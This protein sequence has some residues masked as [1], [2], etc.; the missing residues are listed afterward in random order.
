MGPAGKPLARTYLYQIE[1]PK[2]TFLLIYGKHKVT[3]LLLLDKVNSISDIIL[4]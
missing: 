1:Y 4:L 2:I 3:A